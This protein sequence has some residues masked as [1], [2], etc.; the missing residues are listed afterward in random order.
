M[1]AARRLDF[2]VTLNVVLHRHNLDR[3]E[4]II[5]LAE[6]WDVDRL[7]LAHVQY[8]GWAFRNRAA[9]LPSREQVER[10]AA[11][12]DQARRRDSA[13]GRRFCTSCPIIF[14]SFPRPACTVGAASS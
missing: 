4:E 14:S 12:V 6:R 2:P 3:I 7:E 1:E 10:A 5:D 11:V 13:I 8:T 9:L